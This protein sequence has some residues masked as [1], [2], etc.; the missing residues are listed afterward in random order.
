MVKAPSRSVPICINVNT[1]PPIILNQRFKEYF[2]TL[3]STIITIANSMMIA[4]VSKKLSVS[5][6]SPALPDKNC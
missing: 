1:A 5:S 3:D 4:K 2:K 6:M